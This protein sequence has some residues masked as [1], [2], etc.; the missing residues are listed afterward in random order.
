MTVRVDRITDRLIES[1]TSQID[2]VIIQRM[3]KMTKR[4]T[5]VN[6]QFF[7]ELK[8]LIV[9]VTKA[10]VE[11]IPV[12]GLSLKW[13]KIKN[14]GR[15]SA[16]RFK[17]HRISK[18]VFFKSGKTKSISNYFDRANVNNVFGKPT[19]TYRLGSV[20]G[21]D[22]FEVRYVRRGSKLIPEF[23][24]KRKILSSKGKKIPSSLKA[25]IEVD[26]Y[27]LVG[28]GLLKNNDVEG[29]FP[30]EGIGGNVAAKLANPGPGAGRS[31]ALAGRKRLVMRH[32]MV[33]WMR[34]KIKQ[35]MLG[36]V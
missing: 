18:N 25:V 6:K 28:G 35:A 1:L 21:G 16:Q 32:Y 29:F 3:D 17:R 36:A 12:S 19:L 9:G 34:V 14:P 22:K 8:R 30:Q 11:K 20:A 24:G 7:K 10:P 15:Y 26:P 4:I 27:P 23:H 5:L 2:E 13:D 31:G 33:W